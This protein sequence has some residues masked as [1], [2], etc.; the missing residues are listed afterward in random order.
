VKCNSYRFISTS[1]LLYKKSS[2]SPAF[3]CLRRLRDMLSPDF[4][5]MSAT[6]ACRVSSS[7]EDLEYIRTENMPTRT[8]APVSRI[9]CWWA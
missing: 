1:R 7:S 6:L 4:P 3:F 5:P 2:S 9:D 8:H